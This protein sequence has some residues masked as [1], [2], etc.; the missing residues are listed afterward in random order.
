MNDIKL[1]IYNNIMG[2][3]KIILN[4]QKNYMKN[5]VKKKQ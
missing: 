3:L 2:Y 1:K 4:I 5:M